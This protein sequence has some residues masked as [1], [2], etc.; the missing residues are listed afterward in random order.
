MEMS[1]MVSGIAKVHVVASPSLACLSI[2]FQY[3]WSENCT[4]LTLT[5]R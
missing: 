5:I 3:Q 2:F 4:L 1:D